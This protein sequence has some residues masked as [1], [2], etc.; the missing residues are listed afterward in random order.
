MPRNLRLECLACTLTQVAVVYQDSQLALDRRSNRGLAG[1]VPEN[2]HHIYI[3]VDC[4]VGC[5]KDTVMDGGHSCPS[6]AADDTFFDYQVT[7]HSIKAMELAV[8][9]KRRFFVAA[10]YRRASL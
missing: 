10:G 3:A 8:A 5:D 6:T 1:W 9:A 4:Q 2:D 7:N